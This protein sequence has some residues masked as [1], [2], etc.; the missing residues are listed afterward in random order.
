MPHTKPVDSEWTTLLQGTADS[1]RDFSRASNVLGHEIVSKACALIAGYA[2]G[3]LRRTWL[4]NYVAPLRFIFSAL[5]DFKESTSES[6]FCEGLSDKQWLGFG[7][8]LAARIECQW[9]NSTTQSKQF[10]RIGHV[11]ALLAL[12][13]VFP[14]RIEFLSS[15]G[16]NKP[17]GQSK[18]TKKGHA[19]KVREPLATGPFSFTVKAT[20]RLYNYEEFQPLGRKFLLDALPHFAAYLSGY[21]VERR[22][23]IHNGFVNLLRHLAQKKAECSYDGIFKK[24]ASASYKSMTVDDWETLLYDWRDALVADDSGRVKSSSH[25]IFK[26]VTHLLKHLAINQIVPHLNLPGY[27][28]PRYTQFLALARSRNLAIVFAAT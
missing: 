27:K 14:Y 6:I 11:L 21:S 25:G 19:R 10:A 28:A 15:G 4:D 23:A 22:K 20:G 13:N 12:S 3:V 26:T 18:F 17:N 5:S 24:F 2:T 8:R 7:D 1:T 16:T 9:Q